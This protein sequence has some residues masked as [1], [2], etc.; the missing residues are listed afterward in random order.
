VI[1]IPGSGG[2]IQQG[3]YRDIENAGYIDSIQDDDKLQ[4]GRTNKKESAQVTVEDMMSDKVQDLTRQT[5]DLELYKYYFKSIGFLPLLV[6][7]FF[8]F[9]KVFSGSFSSTKILSHQTESEAKPAQ[10][11]GLNGGLMFM[12]LTSV[13]TSAFISP[14][15]LP[16]AWYTEGIIGRLS[17]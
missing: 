16:I 17:C 15:A 4:N 5:G 10:K 3:P 9:V 6:F 1:V 13:C 14:L 12:E 11:Y 2:Q 8:V 7:L